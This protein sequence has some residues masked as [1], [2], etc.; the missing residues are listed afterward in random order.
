MPLVCKNCKSKNIIRKGTVKTKSGEKQ[1]YLCKDCGKKFVEGKFSHKT[2]GP[3]VIVN[4]ITYYNLGNTLEESSRLINS[5]FKVTTSKSS[6]HRW[7]EDFKNICTYHEIREKVLKNY[8][9]E[10][11]VSKNFE[12]NGLAYNFKYHRAK[13]DILCSRFPSL[14]SYI[15][16]FEMGTP[17]FFDSIENRC[18]QLKLDVNIRREIKQNLACKLADLALKTC[19]SNKERHSAVENFMLINDSCTIA[20]EVP[21]WFWEKNLDAG[22]SGHIDLLQFRD[23]KIF[24]LDFKPQAR[25]EKESRVVSQLYLYASGLSFRARVPLK[26]FR[27]AWFDEKDYY[28][29]N[30]KE[31]KLRFPGSKWRSDSKPRIRERKAQDSVSQSGL[32]SGKEFSISGKSVKKNKEIK[33][34]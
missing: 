19:T 11:L 22:I 14:T 12:H 9:K 5:R 32:G 27:C 30:P 7:L 20:C 8:G 34:D 3:K 29:F 33:N 4:A 17:K 10:I 26:E 31:V 25:K 28:E 24:I 21:V 1:I 2:Y 23:K 6:V 16:K 13:L 15:K 18:S